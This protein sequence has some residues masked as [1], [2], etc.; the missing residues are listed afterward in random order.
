MS[1]PVLGS[2]P[3]CLC[4]SSFSRL[5]DHTPAEGLG[6]GT[7][8]TD[9]PSTGSH[10]NDDT[11]APPTTSRTLPGRT[12]RSS[13]CALLWPTSSAR[14]GRTAHSCKLRPQEVA[15]PTGGSTAHSC[16]LCPKTFS[17]FFVTVCYFFSGHVQAR[18]RWI[19]R[20]LRLFS[21]MIQTCRFLHKTVFI[22]IS[23]FFEIWDFLF[24]YYLFVCK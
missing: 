11:N 4:Q 5:R 9:P 1:L 13:A 24:I 3:S 21:H 17:S 23:F 15:P 2:S 6:G 19:S 12:G 14:R 7:S 10:G 20:L 22:L 16:K 8:H 18:V